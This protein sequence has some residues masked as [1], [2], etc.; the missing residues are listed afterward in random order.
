MRLGINRVAEDLV[1]VMPDFIHEFGDD[2]HHMSMVRTC[3]FDE[4]GGPIPGTGPSDRRYLIHEF[5]D[6][7]I[8][9]P[10][11][12]LIKEWVGDNKVGTLIREILGFFWGFNCG[13]PPRDIALYTV[14]CFRCCPARAVFKRREGKWIKTYP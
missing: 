13:Y 9:Y 11:G 5:M 14:W 4:D 6:D 12:H 2:A 10:I 1:F 7:N 3:D 8:F